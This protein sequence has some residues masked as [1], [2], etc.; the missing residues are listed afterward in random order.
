MDKSPMTISYLLTKGW[1]SFYLKITW[2]FLKDVSIGRAMREFLRLTFSTWAVQFLVPSLY[3][4]PCCLQIFPD[5]RLLSGILSNISIHSPFLNSFLSLLIFLFLRDAFSGTA[6]IHLTAD[7]I[8][9]DIHPSI[10]L[11]PSVTTYTYFWLLLYPRRPCSHFSLLTWHSCPWAPVTPLHFFSWVWPA[12]SL[13]C[14]L[15]SDL[16]IIPSLLI[17]PHHS[18]TTLC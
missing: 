11:A 18:Q 9:S 14:W 12:S 2:V 15:P 7:Y 17:C 13:K 1:S 4:W 8:H 10:K 3:S 6:S 5:L 16:I